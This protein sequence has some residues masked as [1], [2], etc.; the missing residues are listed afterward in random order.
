MV[1]FCHLQAKRF[2]EMGRTCAFLP[3]SFIS[4]ANC[5]QLTW[6]EMRVKGQEKMEEGGNEVW[7]GEETHR[8][9]FPF[10]A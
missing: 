1:L 2:F 7:G 9:R 8:D 6:E 5:L 10:L 3:N 4:L